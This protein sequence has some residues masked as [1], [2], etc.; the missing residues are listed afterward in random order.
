MW[1]KLYNLISNETN[2]QPATWKIKQF[3]LQS[4]TGQIEELLKRERF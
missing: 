2:I 4:K 3:N 1:L